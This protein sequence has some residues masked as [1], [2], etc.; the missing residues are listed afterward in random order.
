MAVDRERVVRCLAAVDAYRASGQKATAWANVNGVA[1][2]DLASWCA[3]AAGWRAWLAG[4]VSPRSK[5]GGGEAARRAQA[6][7]LTGST[8]GSALGSRFV[9]VAVLTDAPMLDARVDIAWPT[10]G[11][12]LT[13][14]WPLAHAR[15]L[16][17][18]LKGLEP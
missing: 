2:R 9:P 4:E 6:Q 15:E 17:V 16:A 10:Q 12:V 13:L 7:S 3:H 5:Q 1:A 8:S 18:W 14:G 11:R